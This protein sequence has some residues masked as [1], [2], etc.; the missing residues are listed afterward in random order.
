VLLNGFVL[1]T[2]HAIDEKAPPYRVEHQGFV[3]LL[4]VPGRMIASK[5]II[6]V[7][8]KTLGEPGPTTHN[9]L[10]A[11][12]VRHFIIADELKVDGVLLG[13]RGQVIEKEVTV[14]DDNTRVWVH[15][16]TNSSLGT[17][18]TAKVYLTE[19]FL[20][21]RKLAENIDKN[22]WLAEQAIDLMIRELEQGHARLTLT[23]VHFVTDETED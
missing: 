3:D 18:L 14:G 21:D 7:D 13:V 4:D 5:R 12:Y 16:M 2:S 1:A 11:D 23:Y 9:I 15:L 8:K 6:S 20:E 22:R 17:G 19:P 10:G